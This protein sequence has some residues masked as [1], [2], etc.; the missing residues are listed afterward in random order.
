ML[1]AILFDIDGT[2]VDSNNYHVLAWAEALHA[3][4]HDFRLRDLHDQIGKGGDNYVKALLPEIGEEKA[5]ALRDA[6]SRLFKQHYFRRLKPFPHARDLLSRCKDQGLKVMLASSASGEELDHHLDVLDARDLV[7]GFTS[8]DDVGCSKPCPEVFI[9]ASAKAG[10]APAEAMVVGDTPWDVE[11]ANAAGI[12]TVAV[13]SG[14]FSD[15]TLA[16]AIAIYDDVADLL[17]RFD[18]SPLNRA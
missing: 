4:G 8:A 5:Q 13:R 6:H 12:A 17:A 11:A 14:L 1:K 7:D 15:P 3:A 16:G 2:L 10:V 18:D 9:T